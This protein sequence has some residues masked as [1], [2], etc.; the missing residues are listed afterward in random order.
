[1]LDATFPLTGSLDTSFNT[2]GSAT[3]LFVANTLNEAQAIAVQADGKVVSVG[4]AGDNALIV[5]FNNDGSLDQTF[6]A[7]GAQPGTLT[8]NL[9]TQSAAYAVALQPMTNQIIIAGYTVI[10]SIDNIFIARYHTDGSLDTTFN[11]TGYITTTFGGHSQLYG[12]KLQLD[13]NIVVTGWAIYQGLTHGLVARYTPEGILDTTF[14]QTGYVATL[15]GGILTQYQALDIKLDGSI[16]VTGQAQL[17]NQGQT[18]NQP[19]FIIAQY[20]STGSLDVSFNNTSGYNFPFYVDN[21]FSSTGCSIAIQTDQ[22]IIAVGS[23]N[24]LQ[25][26]FSNQYYTIVRLNKDGTLDPTFNAQDTP[27]FIV[28]DIG[29]RAHGVVIQS[30]GQIITCGYNYSNNYIA[31]VIA[32]NSDGTVDNSFNFALNTTGTN[33]LGNAIALQPF[34]DKI[35]V[36]GTIATPQ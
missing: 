35:V 33:S 29:L 24:P 15:L 13:G 8:I 5:R 32:F 1:M 12:V 11:G 23:T 14:N 18:N 27:G 28:S 22:K 36:S 34:N 20:S 31:L 26:G 3:N 10:N 30:N 25:T 7:S 16:V 21:F 17:S 6:N 4:Y 9:G 19:A 2:N